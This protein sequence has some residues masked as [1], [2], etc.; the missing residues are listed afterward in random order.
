MKKLIA[1]AAALLSVSSFALSADD[2]WDFINTEVKN[3]HNL[4]MSS[5]YSVFMGTTRTTAFNVCVNG[6]N[7][8]TTKPFPV[9]E[10]VRTNG[11]KDGD[12]FKKVVVGYEVLSFPISREV[13]KTVCYGKRDNRCKTTTEVETQPVVRDIT[14]SKIVSRGG[15][16]KDDRLVELFSKSYEI[17]ACN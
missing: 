12:N 2:T 3:S 9:Y 11:G 17:P 8:N 6:E 13:T 14:I 1:L 5:G 15:R 16:D 4:V 7:F 10:Y